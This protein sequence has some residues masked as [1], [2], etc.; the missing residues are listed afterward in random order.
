MQERLGNMEEKLE[1]N[2]KKAS[3]RHFLAVS[4]AS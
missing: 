1:E 2:T 3:P 4:A